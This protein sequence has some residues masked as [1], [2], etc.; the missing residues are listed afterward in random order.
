MRAVVALNLALATS[1]PAHADLAPDP[2]DPSS[3]PGAVAW[4]AVIAAIA[5][6]AVIW[7]RRRR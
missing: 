7:W 4:V 3:P 6:L 5:A 2:M 1:I